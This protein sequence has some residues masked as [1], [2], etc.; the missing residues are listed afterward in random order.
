MRVVF[1][2]DSF[3]GSIDAAEL[4]RVLAAG[5]ASV[6]PADELVLL[7]QADGGEGTLDAIA[8]CHD[9]AAWH[10]IP[11]VSGPDGSPRT[12][13]WLSLPD[14]T[15]VVEIAQMSGLPLMAELDAGNASTTGLGQV[16]SAALDA[17]A[18]ALIIGLGGSASTDGGSG[19]LRALGARLLDRD[20]NSVDD[21]GLALSNLASVDIENLRAVPAGGVQ[22][23]TDTTA[24]LYGKD[25]AAYIFGPQK[26]ADEG[27]CAELDHAL[28]HFATTL[29][30]TARIDPDRPG[31]GAAGG[32]GF[33]LATW[34]GQLVPGAD[35]IA[36]LT[37]LNREF[38]TADVIV[39]GEGRF[40]RTSLTGKLVGSVL[41]KSANTTTR[42]VVVA[43]QLAASPPDIGVALVDLAGSTE[44]AL[45][46]PARWAHAA[47]AEA[48]ARF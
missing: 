21:G 29:G 3:K 6:R 40:D 46:E 9:G 26:G 34:G 20:G 48:A 42:T 44:A 33:G 43:G 14:G 36:E 18:T 25:G 1:A 22:L 16:I 12:G 8:S 13:R 23:L 5:W 31:A 24:V 41:G 37:G 45:A 4:A 38:G 47:A 10:S 39:T 17:G 30:E 15:A 7:P 11:A 28:E 19:A 27:M 32:T 2:P 35:R